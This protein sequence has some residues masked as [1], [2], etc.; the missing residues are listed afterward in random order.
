MSN[1]YVRLLQRVRGERKAVDAS[2]RHVQDQWQR[3][4]LSLAITPA[5]LEDFQHPSDDLEAIFL[6]RLFSAF[7]GILEEHLAQHHPSIH[8]PEEA[9]FVWLI[10]RVAQ[11][12]PRPITFPL[13]QR[14]REMRRYR[15]FLVHPH[16][17]ALPVLFFPD[18]LA[19]LSKLVE[20]LP[21]PR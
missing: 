5:T 7:E 17:Q 8:V 14:V 20:R 12:Q 18:A 10:D 2:L 15:N 16:G 4:N 11:R 6:I 3:Q 1:N 19:P 13:R 9:R 21:E